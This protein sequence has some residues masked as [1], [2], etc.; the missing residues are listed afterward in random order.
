VTATETAPTNPVE[1]ERWLDELITLE[2]GARH[3][4]TS[5]FTLRRQ[6]AKGLIKLYHVG[7]RAVRVRRREALMLPSPQD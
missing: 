3:R 2:E 4:K 5:K 7:E 1:H 6:A